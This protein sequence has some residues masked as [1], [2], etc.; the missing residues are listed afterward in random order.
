MST[1]FFHSKQQIV[2]TLDFKYCSETVEPRDVCV[3]NCK[4]NRKRRHLKREFLSFFFFSSAAPPQITQFP[5][6]RKVRVGESVELFA[7]VVGTAPITC[8][9]MKFRKQ[10]SCFVVC[11]NNYWKSRAGKGHQEPILSISL[12]QELVKSVSFL[13]DVVLTSAEN[14]PMMKISQSPLA[15]DCSAWVFIVLEVFP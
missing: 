12:P 5:E 13:P 4:K 14:T 6:D 8:T 2:A 9:W 15:T 11:G 10:V 1:E 7:K 3:L